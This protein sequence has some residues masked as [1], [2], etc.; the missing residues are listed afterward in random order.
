MKTLENRFQAEKVIKPDNSCSKAS[1]VNTEYSL[2]EKPGEK[3]DI[4]IW[5]GEWM[6]H[7]QKVSGNSLS[8]SIGISI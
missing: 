1:T 4:H 5:S 7:F 3:N 2:Q 6:G 8:M